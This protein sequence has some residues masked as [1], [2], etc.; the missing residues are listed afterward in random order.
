MALIELE[1][2]TLT[3]SVRR[4]ESKVTARRLIVP[5]KAER[6]LRP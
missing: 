3:G 5:V 1:A 2:V 6:R 4:D